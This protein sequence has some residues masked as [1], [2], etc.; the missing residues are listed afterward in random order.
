MK[1]Q[2]KAQLDVKVGSVNGKLEGDRS[3]VRFEQTNL[4]R[5]LLA[6][7]MERAGADFAVMSGGGIRDSIDAGDITYKDVLKVQPFGNTLV[8]ADMKGSEVEKYLAVVANKKVDSG[9]YAQFANVSLVADGNGV[10]DVKIKGQP[11][12]PN[13]TY[14][15][16]TLN[17]NALGGDGYPKIDT[18]PGYVNTGFID[19]EVLKQYI[20]KHSPLDASQYQPKGEI[21]YK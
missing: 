11:L 4:A 17:F 12:D 5:V 20:E 21:V 13:K 9:A 8:Y 16:A 2:G 3:K 19:A 7:Q 14:R 15:L 6:A 18:L 1:K 10:S